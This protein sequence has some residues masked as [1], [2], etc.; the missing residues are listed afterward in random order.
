MKPTFI[1]LLA[2]CL[3]LAVGCGESKEE[4][5]AKAKAAAAEAKAAADAR[6]IEWAKAAPKPNIVFIFIDDMGYGDIGPF[7]STVNKTPELDRMAAEG[8]RLT[9]FYVSSTACTPSRSALM[10]G[11]YA[12]RI[13]MDGRVNFPGGAR[14]LNPSEITIAE[15][16]KTQGYA[17]GCFGKWHLGDDLSFMPLAQG[18]DEYAGIPYSNDM[19]SGKKRHPPL[20]YIKGNKA[21]AHISNGADQSLLCKATT[22]EA[23]DFIK[24]HKDS[25]FFLYVPHSYIHG[26]RFVRK[27]LLDAAEGNITRAQIEEVDWSTGQ[28][29]KALRDEGLAKK[30]L[31]I[32]TSDN[33]GSGGT[34]MGPLR[35]NKGGNKYEGHMRVP[36]VA[37]WPGTI[38]ADSQT[39][40]ISSTID[41]L[42]T[43]AKLAG[44]T[45]PTD[46]VI[47]GKDVSA[48]L[49]ETN[50][51]SPHQLMFYEFEGIRRGP[52]K[53]VRHG[54][55][56]H[57]H[58]GYTTVELYNLDDDLGEEKN[59]ADQY[60]VM[61]Q[62]LIDLLNK[63]QKS[64]ESGRRPAASVDNPKPFI[65]SGP[66]TGIPALV[67]Y[68]GVPAF[69]VGTGKTRKK[70]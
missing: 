29:L 22:D 52:W 70:Q 38:A 24:R 42:P 2:L 54:N 41:M 68:L 48:L 15:L 32:F 69:E 6:V 66:V 60:P 63:H 35:G 53:V 64:V 9:D 31:V 67:D 45:M 20:P 57:T 28:I 27:E 25:P 40:E 23:V 58:S 18:F 37:W 56:N 10:T 46:R 43:F 50:A 21:V 1:A 5:A 7:G 51:K 14:G 65:P 30:T 17:T 59:L 8:M 12:D 4:K 11:C 26:P 62:E 3:C 36:T 34:S 55:A 44:A 16:L 13:G 33:G 61:M 19:W 47:D 49:I 39:A